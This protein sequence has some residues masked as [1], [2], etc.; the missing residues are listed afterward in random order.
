MH[1][2]ILLGFMCCFRL[3]GDTVLPQSPAILPMSPGNRVAITCQASQAGTNRNWTRLQS[4]SPSMLLRP[5]LGSPQESVALDQGQILYSPSV[6]WILKKLYLI[7]ASKAIIFLSLY[8]NKE[9]NLTQPDWTE[10][11]GNSLFLWFLQAQLGQHLPKSMRPVPHP[12]ELK[13]KLFF[14]FE[15]NVIHT[16]FS[17]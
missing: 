8:Y 14:I 11:L 15:H 3:H 6:T 1:S 13:P 9:Q 4:S 10:R 16:N 2:H 12:A 7:T 17:K 5:C